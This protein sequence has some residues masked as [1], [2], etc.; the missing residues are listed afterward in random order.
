MVE[1]KL[2]QHM[3]NFVSDLFVLKFFKIRT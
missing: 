1:N 2:K 3:S